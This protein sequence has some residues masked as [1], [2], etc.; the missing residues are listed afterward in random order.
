MFFYLQYQKANTMNTI[1]VILQTMMAIVFLYSGINKSIFSIPEL[2]HSKGQTGVD[3]LPLP[4]V[5]F[6]GISEILG[7]VGLIAPWY[8]NILPI[9]TP[10]AASLFA[11]IMVPAAVIHYKRKELK[12]VFVNV[13]L[14]SIC[15]V[16]AY[17]RFHLYG[18]R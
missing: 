2:V 14:F 8:F 13:V 5:R 9:L 3:N 7:S 15:I 1:L 6:I 18:H 10:I 17:Y 4:L 16:I 12:N 11:I